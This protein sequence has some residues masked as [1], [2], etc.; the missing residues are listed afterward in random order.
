MPSC[1]CLKP[2]SRMMPH[3]YQCLSNICGT[4]WHAGLGRKEPGLLYTASHSHH[5]RAMDIV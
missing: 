1:S 2:H 3:P 4:G 5:G